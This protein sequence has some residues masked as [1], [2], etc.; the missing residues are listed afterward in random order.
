MRRIESPAPR[1]R[2]VCRLHEVSR[3]TASL[4]RWVV[5]WL[6]RRAEISSIV[7]GMRRLDAMELD[8]AHAQG[9]PF[10]RRQLSTRTSRPRL[11][12]GHAAA[13]GR[14]EPFTSA[15]PALFATASLAAGSVDIP[16]NVRQRASCL[17]RWRLDSSP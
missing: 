3:G 15:E 8:A 17:A 2:T 1:C 13:S 6:R 12:L 4:V 9:Q 11:Q 14:A 7:W 16:S 5:G 10:I